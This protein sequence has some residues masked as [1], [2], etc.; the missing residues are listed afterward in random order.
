QRQLEGDPKAIAAAGGD[1]R[2]FASRRRGDVPG[3]LRDMLGRGLEKAADLAAAG[4]MLAVR[5]QHDD[6]HPAVRVG[7]LEGDAQ[8]FALTH[9]DDVERRPVEDDVDAFLR[10]IDLDPEAVEPVGLRR[11]P[12]R[13]LGYPASGIRHG[14]TPVIRITAPFR[15]SGFGQGVARSTLHCFRSCKICGGIR[16]N[17]RYAT[18]SASATALAMHTGVL[19]EFPSA[20]PLAPSGVTGEGVSR[21]RIA[22]SGTMPAVGTA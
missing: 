12:R 18:P 14:F 8:L 4:K 3:E 11:A 10:G 7:G 20:T 19:I 21:C 5:A 13:H 16:G 9:R 6:A 2:L 15:G 17:S 1:D 22:R